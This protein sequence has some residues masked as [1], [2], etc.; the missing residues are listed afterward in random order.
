LND[1]ITPTQAVV[2]LKRDMLFKIIPI[3][4]LLGSLSRRPLTLLKI[5]PYSHLF[6]TIFPATIILAAIFVLLIY[7]IGLSTAYIHRQRHSLDIHDLNNPSLESNIANANINVV[8]DLKIDNKLK[9][10]MEIK[11]KH[12]N[13]ILVAFLKKKMLAPLTAIVGDDKIAEKIIQDLGGNHTSLTTMKNALLQSFGPEPKLPEQYRDHNQ[14]RDD[15]LEHLEDLQVLKPTFRGMSIGGSIPNLFTSTNLTTITI[16]SVLSGIGLSALF[17][18]ALPVGLALGLVIG[19]GLGIWMR[20]IDNRQHALQKLNIKNPEVFHKT[21][22]R[23]K[24]ND[25]LEAVLLND[26]APSKSSTSTF[27]PFTPLGSFNAPH[28]ARKRK[29][30]H[31]TPVTS[32]E[33]LV[34]DFN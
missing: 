9:T 33:S 16:M 1:K 6:Q 4:L 23:R 5:I 8:L 29:Y 19:L 27:S 34:G 18:I 2:H 10:I 31:A 20:R 30:I 32:N 26:F 25:A 12:G 3:L 28:E 11:Q 13:D 7:D 22:I 21:D 15:A 17:P 14:T 24:L